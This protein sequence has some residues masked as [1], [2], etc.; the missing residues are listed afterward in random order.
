MSTD[1]ASVFFA[2]LSLLC[3]AGV[4]GVVVLSLLR[5]SAPDS[6]AA[7]LFDDIGRSALWLAALVAVVTMGGSL[8]Y[9][10]V[11]GF[12]PCELCW[13]Q[14]IAMYPL[15]LLLTIAAVRRDDRIWIYAVP[16]AAIGAAIAVYHTQLQAF[17]DQGGFCSTTTP[18]TTRYVWE[19]KFVSLPFMALSAFAFIITMLLVA[20]ATGA[21]AEQDDEFEVDEHEAARP[22]Q[23]GAR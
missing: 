4:I 17:P 9:S 8:Y 10:Q 22:D 5:R 18:C 3:V 16:Q 13:F 2:L 1:T 19:F 20:R 21:D 23:V 14:R 11:A 6:A 12:V 15:A 7:G